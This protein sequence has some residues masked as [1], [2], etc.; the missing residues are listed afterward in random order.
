[1]WAAEFRKRREDLEIDPKTTTEENIDRV[2]RIVMDDRRLIMSYIVNLFVYPVK[3]VR[4]FC[5]KKLGIRLF[6]AR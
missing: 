6:S 5:V 1:M 2:Y 3:D 4:T